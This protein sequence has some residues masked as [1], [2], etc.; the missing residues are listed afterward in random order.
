MHV[1]TYQSYDIDTEGK[2][3]KKASRA[4]ATVPE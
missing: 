4:P 3:L 2:P 1:L